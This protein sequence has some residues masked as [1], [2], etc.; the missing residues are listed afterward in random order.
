ML[1]NDLLTQIEDA[2]FGRLSV[3][4]QASLDVLLEKDEQLKEGANIYQK[5]WQ[6]LGALKSQQQARLFQQWDAE[7]QESDEEELIEWF[8][9]GE[10]GEKTTENIT[11][12]YDN[13]TDFAAK[14][15]A[16]RSLK[17]GFASLQSTAF[18]EKMN[19]WQSASPKAKS[20]TL[21]TSWR[22]PLSIA[23]GFLLLIT[24]SFGWWNQQQYS[25]SALVEKYSDLAATGSLLGAGS[26]S[27]T[28]LDAFGE[29][30]KLLKEAHFEQAATAFRELSELSIP[31]NWSDSFKKTKIENV[32]WNL[33][34]SLLGSQQTGGDFTQKLDRIASTDG[35]DYQAKAKALQED[36]TSFWRF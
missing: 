26:T 2:H 22:R 1:S 9:D 16:H 4:E 35:H 25:D 23:A 13:D 15:D 28:Y 7:W 36:V 34:I 29:A 10:L 17:E 31:D 21:K 30:H 20:R 18:R 12:K 32:E 8:V 27:D 33:I 14:V 3:E 5:I 19:T 11:V 24:T 6:G